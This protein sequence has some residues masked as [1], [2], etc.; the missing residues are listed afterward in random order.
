MDPTTPLMHW[1]IT[2]LGVLMMNNGAAMTGNVIEEKMAGSLDMAGFFKSL[3]V[4]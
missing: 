1:A 2:L 4:A 3:N